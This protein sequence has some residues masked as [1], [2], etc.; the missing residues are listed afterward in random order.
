MKKKPKKKTEKK[1]P[2][3]VFEEYSINRSGNSLSHFLEKK[4]AQRYTRTE[5]SLRNGTIRTIIIR[6]RQTTRCK[7]DEEDLIDFSIVLF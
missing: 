7:R 2:K 3:K 1:D 5:I 6:I 4:C